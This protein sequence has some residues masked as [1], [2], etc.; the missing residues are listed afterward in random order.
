ME[1]PE[2]PKHQQETTVYEGRESPRFVNSDCDCISGGTYSDIGDH[3]CSQDCQHFSC[4]QQQSLNEV[5]GE[6]E[7]S[8]RF[9]EGDSCKGISGRKGRRGKTRNSSRDESKKDARQA[10]ASGK[11][12]LGRKKSH[13][14][15]RHQL[16]SL[17]PQP[18][19]QF[20]NY[21]I[22]VLIDLVLLIGECVESLGMLLYTTVWLPSHN[23]DSLRRQILTFGIWVKHRAKDFWVLIC[24]CG[25]WILRVLKMLCALLFLLFM[26]SVRCARLCWQY[27]KKTVDRVG[28][29]STW[30]SWISTRLHTIWA[31]VTQNRTCKHLVSLFRRWTGKLW[32]SKLT[33]QKE[34]SWT[35]AGSP[36][37]G[38]RVQPRHE[39]ERLLS[40]VD[41][42]EEDLN[43]FQVLG[44]EMNASDVELKKAYRQLAVL[45]HPDKN[46]HPRAEEAF[47][48]LRAAW[49][50]VSN[51]DKRKEFELKRMS[52][53]ELAKSMNEF[54]TKLQDDLKEAMNSMMCSK[55]QGKHRRFEMDRDPASARYCA[56]CGK[57]HPAEEGDFWA[58]SSMLGL[59]ITYFAMMQG[60]VF[61]ITEWAGCQRVGI[62]PDTHRVPYHISFGS[63]NSTNS[64]RQRAPS[65]STPTSV[66]DLQNL[67]SRL[68]QG[69][70]GQ[71]PNG[72]LF[73]PPP[74]A[75]PHGAP[76]PSA[77]SKPDTAF[78]SET[79]SKR[80]KK[81]RRPVQK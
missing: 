20:S 65:E 46:N 8:G 81:M 23:L 79:K 43:P 19:L 54:L 40:M 38:G 37:T 29:D 50:T 58:E 63:R 52:E 4:Y 68:F 5:G 14:D 21:C 51:P 39:L 6:E 32:P 30:R 24:Y 26:L 10:P 74:Q 1:F 47:K 80:K 3:T 28:E 17:I 48:V 7:I 66:A 60:K 49:D 71:M 64:G 62:S 76:S 31:L 77:P 13:G 18:L 72:N 27:I 16:R 2:D 61:D 67:L 69:S 9:A 75:P 12:K 41:I 45:V 73:T 78:K 42:P 15:G 70:P 55:C 36:S 35:S 25:S 53:T 44:V 57:M 56:E 22:Q 34:S 59:K 11:H 33:T